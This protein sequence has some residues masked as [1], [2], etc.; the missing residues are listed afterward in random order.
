MILTRKMSSDVMRFFEKASCT[1]MKQIFINLG[2]VMNIFKGLLKPKFPKKKNQSMCTLLN[3]D[4]YGPFR[5]SN[6]PSW[7]MSAISVTRNAQS[8]CFDGCWELSS[9][10]VAWKRAA[11]ISHYVK[12]VLF[13]LWSSP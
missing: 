12:S 11:Q 2:N 3:P 7:Q 9:S 8:M 13:S 5:A 4:K 1:F 10:V 6:S